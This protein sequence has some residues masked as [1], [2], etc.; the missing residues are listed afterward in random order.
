L[1]HNSQD[2]SL[3]DEAGREIEF[4][5]SPRHKINLGLNWGPYHGFSTNLSLNWKDSVVTPDFWRTT[6]NSVRPPELQIGETIELESHTLLNARVNYAVPLGGK[7]ELDIF[8]KATDLLDEAPT[9]SL[10]GFTT[11][12]PGREVFA[13]IEFRRKH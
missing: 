7:N 8:I 10:V 1:Q 11:E 9:E 13:G 12:A 6:R 3:T 4:V 5:Y 2:G